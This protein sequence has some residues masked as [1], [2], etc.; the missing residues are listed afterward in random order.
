MRKEIILMGMLYRHYN[1]DVYRAIM[2]VRN[3]ANNQ[4][5]WVYQNIETG[6]RWVRP[7]SEF[8]AKFQP[9]LPFGTK[10]KGDD[11]EFV[12]IYVGEDYYC[13]YCNETTEELRLKFL[14]VKRYYLLN[15][16][17]VQMETLDG[18]TMHQFVLNL[19]DL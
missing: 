16:V 7:E 8:A 17:V 5:M 19:K 2:P 6:E 12:V 3:E 1:G 4:T 10:L 14:D 15:H 13:L 11:K 18:N 9:H